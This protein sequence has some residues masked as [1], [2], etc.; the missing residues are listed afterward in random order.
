MQMEQNENL[1]W[2][3]SYRCPTCGGR[4]QSAGFSGDP[5]CFNC[6]KYVEPI[7]ATAA[8]ETKDENKRREEA[9]R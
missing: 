4:V 5:F 3:E 1:Q 7:Q 8:K 9:L 6:F 2:P